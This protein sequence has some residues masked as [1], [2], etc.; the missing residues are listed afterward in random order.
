MR[1]AAPSD[2]PRTAAVRK[3]DKDTAMRIQGLE[4]TNE[5]LK[6]LLARGEDDKKLVEDRIKSNVKELVLPYVEKLKLTGLTVEQQTYLEIIETT[7]KNVFSSFLQKITSK[8]Y[9]FT[10]KE[11]QVATLI[12]EGKTTKQIADI[13]K[14]TRSAIGLHRHHIRNKLGLGKAKVNLRS[15]LL[16]LQ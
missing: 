9:H 5:A 12:R 16:S 7:I 10:P 2:S 8:Q 14:V 3:S 6:I 15:Y 4:E 13:M 1:S 11:I